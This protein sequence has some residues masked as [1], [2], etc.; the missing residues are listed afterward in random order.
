[1]YR[2]ILSAAQRTQDIVNIMLL[3]LVTLL[4]Y[5]VFFSSIISENTSAFL[6][7]IALVL[8]TICQLSAISSF[9]VFFSTHKLDSIIGD[10][11]EPLVAFLAVQ[12][13]LC[14]ILEILVRYDY[15][16]TFFCSCHALVLIVF[17]TMKLIITSLVNTFWLLRTSLFNLIIQNNRI[18][19]LLDLHILFYKQVLWLGVLSTVDLIFYLLSVIVDLLLHIFIYF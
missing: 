15:W 16:Y 5:L 17:A 8:L 19:C 4:Y 2:P 18:L 6:T 1:M 12:H 3:L 10:S 13:M 11:T 14:F 7:V 9:L